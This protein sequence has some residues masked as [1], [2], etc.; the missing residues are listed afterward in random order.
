MIR[1]YFKTTLR[2]IIRYPVHSFLNIAG[3][4]IG[5]ACAFLILL[6]IQDEWSYGRHYENADE[7]YRVLENQYYAG[8]ELFQVAVTPGPLAAALKEEYPE[9]IRASRYQ[10]MDV[11]LEKDNET[12][13]ESF[14]AIDQD[15]IRM[16]DIQFVQGDIETALADP[17]N[18]IITE[19]MAN[20]YFGDENP[21]GKTFIVWRYFTFNVRGVVRKLPH[22]SHFNFDFLVPFEFLVN[23]EQGYKAWYNNSIYTY[24]ELQKGTD[25]KLLNEKI[26]NTIQKHFEQTNTEIFL[27]NVKKIHLYSAGKYTADMGGLGD[28]TYVRIFSLIA[29]FILVIAC[30]NFMNLSTAQ[31][32]RRAKEI[33]MR[34]IAG[35]KKGKIVFQFLGESILIVFMAHIIA[36]ILVEILLPGFNILTSKQLDVNYMGLPLYISLISIVLFCGLLAGSYPALYLS[37]FDAIKVVKG[38][39]YRNPGNAGFR[40]ILVIFQFTL[41]VFLIICTLTIGNQVSYLQNNKLGINT[42]N[43]GYFGSGPAIQR[44]PMK[45]KLLQNTDIISVATADQNPVNMV[46]S[47]GGITWEGQ[48]EGDILFHVVYVD[49]DYARTFKLE[50]KD[51]RFFSDIYTTDTLAVVVNEKASEIIGSDQVIGKFLSIGDESYKIIGIVKDFNFKSLHTPIEPLIMLTNPR[52]G[53]IYF[54]RMKPENTMETVKF[55]ESAYKSFDPGRPI[56]FHFLE[57]DYENLYRTEQRTGTIFNFS[58]LLAIM[59]SCL[60]LIGLSS[61]MAA[62]RTKEIGIRKANGAETFEIFTLLS[63]EYVFWVLISIAIASPVSWYAMNRWLQNF[64]YRT[65]INWLMFALAGIIAITIAL[66]TI[67]LQSWRAAS[68]NPVEA[69]RYE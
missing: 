69:L 8:E 22:N 2:Y 27:Q 59:I 19:E 66:L 40:R 7:L 15:F 61:F 14:A 10:S 6:W 33:G 52:V 55:I 4:S 58:S 24:V 41:S 16:F 20:K 12:M 32:A 39:E 43:I 49:E 3:L 17:N 26:I 64:A 1:N 35:A 21:M 13:N 51:G 56:D 54:I 37:S 29:L 53:G 36:M 60:G 30:I 50:I 34:K 31:S 45:N 38:L 63:R 18:I 11:T 42:D 48:S 68:R 44:K 46:N 5:M 23:V 57:D 28:I 62:R 65:T 67:S 25:D 47:R 9:I